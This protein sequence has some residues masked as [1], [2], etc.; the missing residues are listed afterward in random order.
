MKEKIDEYFT[1]NRDKLYSNVVRRVNAFKGRIEPE[2][3]DDLINECYI[4][5]ITN[6]DKVE[7]SYND[8]LNNNKKGEDGIEAFV[9]MWLRNQSAWSF[10]PFKR[11]Y[12]LHRIFE[13]YNP[14]YDD[15]EVE[16]DDSLYTEEYKDLIRTLGEKDTNRIIELNN[17][18]KYKLKTHEK[19]LFDLYYKEKISINDIAILAQISTTSVRNILKELNN[20]LKS[21]TNGL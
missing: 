14:I 1:N 21:N 19:N 3:W 13:E 9:I 6:I 11:K 10:T 2:L 12:E 16:F 20:K 15:R 7:K 8:K 18:Y 4:Y 5:C 17:I